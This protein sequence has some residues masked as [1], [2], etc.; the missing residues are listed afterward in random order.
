M[1]TVRSLLAGLMASA[2]FIIPGISAAATS[3]AAVIEIATFQLKQGVTPAEFAVVDKAMEREYVARQPGFMSREAAAGPNHEWLVIVH[4]KSLKDADASMASFEKA[5]PTR[6][7]MAKLDAST[8]SMKRYQ[9][10][11]V[12]GASTGDR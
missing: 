5:E 3:G 6:A 2:M 7:F 9:K 12:R 1:K 10:V 11:P 8:M 4:W